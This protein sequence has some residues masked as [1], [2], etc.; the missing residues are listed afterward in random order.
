MIPVEHGYAV[1][2]ARPASRLEVLAGVGHFPHV[3]SPTEVVTAIEAFIADSHD[4]A[5]VPP[6]EHSQS[7]GSQGI[8]AT[9]DDGSSPDVGL[10][11]TIEELE[12]RREIE[13]AV[14]ILM[15]LRRCSHG[16]AVNEYL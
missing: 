2:Q 14:G 6:Q 4:A 10:P 13:V 1:Q 5:D 8:S 9:G 7:Q 3:E 16:E 12:T 11:G 15:D